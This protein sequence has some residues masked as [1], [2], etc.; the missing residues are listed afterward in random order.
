MDKEFLLEQLVARLRR[1]ATVA[2]EAGAAAAVEARD[3]ATPAERREDA[4]TALEFGALARGQALRA[5]RTGEEIEALAQFRPA[6]LP[7]GARVGLGAVVEIE[8]ESDGGSGRTFFLAPAGAG[9]EL[10]GPGGDGVLSV[11]TPTSPVGRAVMGRR[12]GDE[13][14]VVVQGRTRAWTIT[15]VA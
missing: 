1:S 5:H 12:A 9:V 6:P 2:S 13:I 8:D 10:S 3:G 4:R 14:E 15:Y 7:P 11:V